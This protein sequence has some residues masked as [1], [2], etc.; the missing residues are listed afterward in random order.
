MDTCDATKPLLMGLLDGELTAEQLAEVSRHLNRCE[1]CRTEYEEL[2]RD[3]DPLRGLSFEEPDRQQLERFWKAPGSRFARRA[4]QFLVLL[5]CLVLVVFAAVE[6]A[7][8]RAA[9]LPLKL[10]LSGIAVGMLILFLNVL[11]QRLCTW[12]Q[13][14]YREVE[15]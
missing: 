7:R 5:G 8:D 12:R 1:A 2:K 15:R 4:G 11:L 3:C 14:P 13:D 10:G 6:I 9:D